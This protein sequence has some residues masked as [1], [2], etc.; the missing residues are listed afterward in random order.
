MPPDGL[1][2]RNLWV[3]IGWFLVLSVV[4]LSLVPAPPPLPGRFGDKGGHVL[5]YASLMFW[6]GCL[7]SGRARVVSAMGLAVMGLGL[8]L[9][10]GLGG[11]R[12]AE[13]MDMG[14]NA[15]GII[16]GWRLAHT[17]AF[18]LLARFDAWL[19]RLRA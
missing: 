16:I 1:I 4:Y 11:H 6:F 13:P 2:Y 17:R 18:G 19:G 10:Q 8:E 15:L 14:A 7:Y 5:A 3:T 9:L 12:S